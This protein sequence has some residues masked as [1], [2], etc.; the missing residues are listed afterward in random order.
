[1]GV[2]LDWEIDYYLP[3][4]FAFGSY[5]ISLALGQE[6]RLRV[7]FPPKTGQVVKLVFQG[8]IRSRKGVKNGREA[9]AAQSG[10]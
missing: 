10:V 1:M 4:E 6:W 8:R 5:Q 7:S 9:E 3:S 2:N